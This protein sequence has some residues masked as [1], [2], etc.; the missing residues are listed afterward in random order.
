MN[1]DIYKKFILE[2][3]TRW[4]DELASALYISKNDIKKYWNELW[5]GFKK[6]PRTM[7]TIQYLKEENWKAIYRITQDLVVFLTPTQ[8][9]FIPKWTETDLGSVPKWARILVDKDDPNFL[10]PFLVHDTI[11][12][13]QIYSRAIA[14]QLLY[15]LA[16]ELWAKWYKKTLVYR[17]VRLWGW[18]TW[19]SHWPNYRLRTEINLLTLE[20]FE[21]QKDNIRKII[22]NLNILYS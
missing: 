20:Y 21:K 18:L 5:L 16:S 1:N 9:I 14:D 8:P 2:N 3:K 6:I 22:N 17:A 19:Y 13:T 4:F 10:I 12:E 7:A 15:D 11:Y